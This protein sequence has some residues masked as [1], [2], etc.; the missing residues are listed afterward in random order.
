MLVVDTVGVVGVGVGFGVAGLILQACNAPDI[1]SSKLG[2]A[3]CAE[4]A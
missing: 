1:T 3:E 4:C 2:T